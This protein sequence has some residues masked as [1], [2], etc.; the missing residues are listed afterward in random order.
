MIELLKQNRVERTYRGGKNISSFTGEPLQSDFFPED[1]TTSTISVI[2]SDGKQ[3]GLGTTKSGKKIKNIS[4]PLTYLLKLLDSEERLVVQVHPTIEFAKKHFNSVYGKTECWYILNANP[5]SC[6]Y[7]GFKP[8]ISKTLWRDAVLSG[9]SKKILSLLNRINIHP[10]D[11]IFVEGGTPHA[12]GENIFLLEAQEPTDFM[13]VAEK[14]TPSGVKIPEY[15]LTGG[16]DFETALDMYS[17]IGYTP[18]ET[19]KKYI[20]H[21]VSVPDSVTQILKSP[22]NIRLVSGNADIELQKNA[23]AVILD[24]YGE[25]SGVPVKKGDRLFLYGES[26]I[27]TTGPSD[28]LIYLCE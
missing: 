27:R 26:G 18:E 6:V 23:A 9:N 14:F 17:Y 13:A 10:G 2:G 21:P 12:I 8:G 19:V 5:E 7:L 20:S 25:I 15:R 24:G 3:H 11:F 16:I 4:K 22:F 1:W 28:F